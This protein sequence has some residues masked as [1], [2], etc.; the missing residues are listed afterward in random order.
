MSDIRSGE[1]EGLSKKIFEKKWKPDYGPIEFNELSGAT[2]IGCRDFLIAYNINLNTKNKRLATDI[3]FDLREIGR[4]KRIPNPL[5]NNLLDGEIVRKDD[6][7]PIKVRGIFKDVK[8]IGWY[9]EE[10][11]CSQVS[12]NINNY[13]KSTLHDIFDATCNLAED[14]GLRVTGSELIGLI[15]LDA[16]LNAGQHYLKKQ[17]ST[18]GLP[19]ADVIE[20][21]IKS[22]GLNDVIPFDPKTRIIEYAIKD[23]NSPLINMSGEN[24]LNELSRSSPAPGGGSVAAMVGAMAAAL[25]SMVSSLNYGKKEYFNKRDLFE[26]IGKKAQNLK[27][28]LK[29]LVD[30]DT[31]SF[32]RIIEANRLPEKDEQDKEQKKIKKQDAIK[33]AIEIPLSTAKNC[34]SILE[35]IQLIIPKVN[36]NSISD[37]G[38]SSEIAIAAIRSACMNVWINLNDINSDKYR[39]ELILITQQLIKDSKE[40]HNSNI[41]FV[42]NV[43]YD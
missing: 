23:N 11:G 40:I 7:S 20:C 31:H 25:S 43:I 21:A 37:L 5:S 6:G 42:K 3:A 39:E 16:I 41:D 26:D 14:R 38:V 36:P 30:E 32:N 22:L 35:I 12:I 9:V 34:F 4:S 27:D 28:E 19:H 15:P 10:Y 1:Y 24:F 33:Y 17:N 18:L 13:H 2:V 29:Y 8:A